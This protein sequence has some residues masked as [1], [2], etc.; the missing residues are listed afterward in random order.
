MIVQ[1]SPSVAP[2]FK[3]LIVENSWQAHIMKKEKLS[4]YY[5][6]NDNGLF[7]ISILINNIPVLAIIDTGSTHCSISNDF[8]NGYNLIETNKTNTV[9]PVGGLTSQNAYIGNIQFDKDSFIFKNEIIISYPMVNSDFKFIIG[10]SL[11]SK[12]EYIF[13]KNYNKIILNIV[14]T[15][16]EI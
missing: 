8:I 11:L 14:E 9:T 10:N 16:N 12:C 13:D 2:E 5:V 1:I 3:P 15:S 7:K 6:L 4:R